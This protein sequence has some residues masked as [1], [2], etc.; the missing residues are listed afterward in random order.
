MEKE[1][2]INEFIDW[3]FQTITTKEEFKNRLTDLIDLIT[4][5]YSHRNY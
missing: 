1:K 3:A 4:A 5:F 2:I